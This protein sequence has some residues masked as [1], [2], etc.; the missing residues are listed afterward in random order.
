MQSMNINARPVVCLL[1]MM[2]SLC[3]SAQHWVDCHHTF[4][5]N[6]SELSVYQYATFGKGYGSVCPPLE[7]FWIN[8]KG[9]SIEVNVL[10]N[11]TGAYPAVGCIR[12]DTIIDTLAVCAPCSLI[13]NA[14][15]MG[16]HDT[17]SFGLDTVW[18]DD[19]DT[20]YFSYLSTSSGY[21]SSHI[22]IY[23]NPASDF[24]KLEGISER[25][26]QISLLDI[27]GKVVR[28]FTFDSTR[29]NLKGIRS[30]VY[31]LAIE[32]AEGRRVVKRLLL[33]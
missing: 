14:H 13:V 6:G 31:F 5:L 26:L 33:E 22:N 2:V 4:H 1:L 30:G 16:Y 11:D 28:I 32:F 27:S 20:S 25:P 24:A 17:T 18:Y 7:S 3:G 10:Y 12:I 8:K 15:V 29:L 9:N 19:R 21:S 23:P